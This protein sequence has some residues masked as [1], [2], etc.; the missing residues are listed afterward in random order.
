MGSDTAWGVG[1]GLGTMKGEG[2]MIPVDAAWEREETLRR[3]LAKAEEEEKAYRMTIK[4]I[5]RNIRLF[6]SDAVG[7]GTKAGFE[8]A[9]Q[10]TVALMYKFQQEG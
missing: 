9:C 4:D 8:Q 10:K 1:P 7:E 3:Q 6:I 5:H 2:M